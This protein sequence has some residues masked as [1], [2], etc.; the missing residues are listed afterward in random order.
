VRI[1]SLDPSSTVTGYAV[2]I[3]NCGVEIIDAGLIKPVR[4]RDP[5]LARAEQ[6]AQEIIE[7]C[8]GTKI[9][10]VVIELPSP[11]APAKIRRMVADLAK[12]PVEQI[13][14]VLEKLKQPAGQAYYGMAVGVIVTTIKWHWSMP[15]T[16]VRADVWSRG[17]SKRQR[18]A[19]LALR[20]PSYDPETDPGADVSDAVGLLE[21]FW[22]E[23]AV[24]AVA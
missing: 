2:G 6:M 21:W 13:I 9:D 8:E 22:A 23:H 18:Q 24:G 20:M 14:Q 5:A 3:T 7:L 4:T 12:L 1:L 10:R 19:E 11:Q 15:C 16:T 17:Q